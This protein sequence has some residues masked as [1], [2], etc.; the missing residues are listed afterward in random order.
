MLGKQKNKAKKHQKE[1][2]LKPQ[3]VKTKRPKIQT[4]NGR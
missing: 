3:I 1:S 2:Y 4:I